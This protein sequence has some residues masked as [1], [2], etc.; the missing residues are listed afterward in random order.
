MQPDEPVQVQ[1]SS[2]VLCSSHEQVR[3]FHFS[4]NQHMSLPRIGFIQVE[5]L[6]VQFPVPASPKAASRQKLSKSFYAFLHACFC[7]CLCIS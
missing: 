1:S 3:A 5:L 6:D 2:S 4:F 7:L